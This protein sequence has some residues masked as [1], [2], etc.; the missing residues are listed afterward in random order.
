MYDMRSNKVAFN[1]PLSVKKI[2]TVSVSSNYMATAGLENCVSLWDVRKLG[3]KGNKAIGRV[4]YGRSVTSAFFNPAGD[5]ILTTNMEDTISVL[6]V[7][8]GKVSEG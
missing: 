6:P 2:N 5:K 1:A 3:A 7:K 8:A 4:D